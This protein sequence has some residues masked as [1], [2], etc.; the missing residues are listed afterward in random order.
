MP[1]LQVSQ[2]ATN[3][4]EAKPD[5]PMHEESDYQPILSPRTETSD[6]LP[7]IVKNPQLRPKPKT[8]YFNIDYLSEESDT[9]QESI[10]EEK[11]EDKEYIEEEQYL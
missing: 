3:L 9:P 5:I 7:L 6:S 4:E 8:N 10:E 11:E 2:S 1:T